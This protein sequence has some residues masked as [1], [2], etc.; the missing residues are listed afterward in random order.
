MSKNELK[1]FEDDLKLT[2]V[3]G[4][5]IRKA[6]TSNIDGR[7]KL[8]KSLNDNIKLLNER[9]LSKRKWLEEKF[10]EKEKI[11]NNLNKL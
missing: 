9:D 6:D 8:S 3:I 2:N 11:I 1:I 4:E 7:I 10:I 5:A